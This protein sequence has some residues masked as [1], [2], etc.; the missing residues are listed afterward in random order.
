MNL[1]TF[2]VV[3]PG[4]AAFVIKVYGSKIHAIIQLTLIGTLMQI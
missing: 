1:C 3:I 2:F 4:V